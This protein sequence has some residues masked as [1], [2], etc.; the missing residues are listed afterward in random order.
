MEFL[1]QLPRWDGQDHIAAMAQRVP[2]NNEHWPEDFAVWMR[3]MMAQWLHRNILHGNAMVP[4]LIGAQG[5][6]KSTFCRRLL[7]DELADYYTDRIDFANRNVAERMLTRFCLIN[8]DEYDSLSHQ[9]GAFLKHVLQKADKNA[10]V[11]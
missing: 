1:S 3:A 8:I 4:L 2:T 11:V 7:P 9:Q 5:D 10:Q 6:G